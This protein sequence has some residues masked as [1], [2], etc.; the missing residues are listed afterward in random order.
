MFFLL[1][2][3][4]L[5]SVCVSVHAAAPVEGLQSLRFMAESCKKVHWDD[6]AAS[7]YCIQEQCRQMIEGS[8][9]FPYDD[10][11]TTYDAPPSAEAESRRFVINQEYCGLVFPFDRDFYANC[12]CDMTFKASRLV[13]GRSISRDDDYLHLD[14]DYFNLNGGMS[15]VEIACAQAFGEDTGGYVD[16]L[17]DNDVISQVGDGSWDED[18]ADD[19]DLSGS[20]VSSSAYGRPLGRSKAGWLSAQEDEDPDEFSYYWSSSEFDQDNLK[21]SG[22]VDWDDDTECS[23]CRLQD[24]V[25]EAVLGMQTLQTYAWEVLMQTMSVMKRY[26]CNHDTHLRGC[27]N[28]LEADPAVVEWVGV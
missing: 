26:Q 2:V 14:D 9:P 15:A 28:T 13:M 1:I 22:Y 19:E 18:S 8:L 4:V 11:Y 25:T 6:E 20:D 12:L 10:D 27:G 3:P 5:A 23:T 16:C 21:K 17:L 7:D 24:M